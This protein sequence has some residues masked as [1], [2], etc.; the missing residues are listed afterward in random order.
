MLE[1]VPHNLGWLLRRAHDLGVRARV[2]CKALHREVRWLLVGAAVAAV[3][4]SIA[5][6]GLAAQENRVPVPRERVWSTPHDDIARPDV[7]D[8]LG[9]FEKDATGN[10]DI[11]DKNGQRIGVGKPRSDGRIDLY[12]TK[13][14]RGLEVSPERPR[15]K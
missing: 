11:Y 2:L 10:Y 15:R 9:R 7:T 8:R 3:L 14:R 6:S 12:D 1:V 4:A 5:P 13:G